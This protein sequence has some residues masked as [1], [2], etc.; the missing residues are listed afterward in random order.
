MEFKRIPRAGECYRHF[1]GNRYQILTIAKHTE[2]EEELVI[3]EGLYDDHPVF[4]RPIELFIS[5]VDKNKYPEVLQEYRFE[6]EDLS[7]R[8][9]LNDFLELNSNKEK[10]DFLQINKELIDETFLASAAL[11]VDF[12]ERETTL[13]ERYLDFTKYLRTLTKFEKR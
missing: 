3:Y 9:L 1:K 10:L 6:L 8:N 5:K 4:A 12:V 2:T 11:T 13:E 7:N